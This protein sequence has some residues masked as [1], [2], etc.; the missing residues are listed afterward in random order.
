[1]RGK[2]FPTASK[3]SLGF[4]LSELL[5]VIAIIAIL[6]SLSL[7][8]FSRTE[9]SAKSIACRSNLRQIGLALSLYVDDFEVYPLYA[10]A[11]RDPGDR[12]IR[13]WDKA[14]LPYCGRNSKLFQCPAWKPADIWNG[15]PP[16]GPTPEYSVNGFNFCYGYNAFGTRPP[17]HEAGLGLGGVNYPNTCP[18]PSGIVL[19]PSEM[20][21]I[22]DYRG[23]MTYQAIGLLNPWSYVD[24]Q[25]KDYLRSRHPQGANVTFCDSHVESLGR[26]KR[27]PLSAA[28]SAY[29]KRWNNDNQPHSETWP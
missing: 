28:D 3:G 4:T 27:W 21:A 24:D 11:S 20:I 8:A 23:L 15:G 12:Q 16:T 17:P 6:G 13:V 22:G 1:M 18:V 14:L 10:D 5:V 29:A 2:A 9:V 25:S 26:K 19:K 7:P